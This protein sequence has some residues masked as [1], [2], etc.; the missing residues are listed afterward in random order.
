MLPGLLQ[1]VIARAGSLSNTP[2]GRRAPWYKNYTDRFEKGR[3][4]MSIPQRPLAPHLTGVA[5]TRLALATWATQIE[6]ARRLGAATWQPYM[7]RPPLDDATD[8]G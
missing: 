3:P 8:A 1:A 7:R 2:A 4:E 5:V 6:T